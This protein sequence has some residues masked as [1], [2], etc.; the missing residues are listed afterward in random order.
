MR[1]QHSQTVPYELAIIQIEWASV[2]D[3]ETITGGGMIRLGITLKT[4]I[5]ILFKFNW[6]ESMAILS[7]ESAL[8]SVLIL[9]EFVKRN[10]E[11]YT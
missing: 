4:G 9:I 6:I 8:E 2:N 7:P 5:G 10:R 3:V 1:R 11:K